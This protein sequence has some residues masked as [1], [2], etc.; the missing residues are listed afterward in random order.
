M[1]QYITLC[2]VHYYFQNY[3]Q[4][5]TF[6]GLYFFLT[7]ERKLVQFT[8]NLIQILIFK[9]FGK[10]LNWEISVEKGH[11]GKLLLSASIV[12]SYQ[13]LKNHHHWIFIFLFFFFP[14]DLLIKHIF[15]MIAEKKKPWEIL[16][17][18]SSKR[19]FL[20]DLLQSIPRDV[21]KYQQPF[22]VSALL[23]TYCRT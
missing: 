10:V 22:S 6:N 13:Q 19:T 23:K 14:L 15:Q 4:T 12:F 3:Y 7:K 2:I 18:S 5:H 1:R 20:W 21:I 8:Y 16:I 17:S 9:H 11:T